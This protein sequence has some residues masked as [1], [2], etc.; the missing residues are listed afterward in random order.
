MLGAGVVRCKVLGQRKTGLRAAQ[1]ATIVLS[2][3]HVDGLQAGGACFSKRSPVRE[4]VGEPL[5]PSVSNREPMACNLVF[6][7]SD[8]SAPRAA[9]S[10]ST[11]SPCQMRACDSITRIAHNFS[12]A[13]P[14][15]TPRSTRAKV[16]Q[17]SDD[18]SNL[19]RLAREGKRDFL[20]SQSAIQ[21][22]GS[23]G[24]DLHQGEQLER[25]TRI[26]SESVSTTTMS[27]TRLP[28]RSAMAVAE[29]VGMI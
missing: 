26:E 2:D 15:F 28:S 5:Q 20:G 27:E 18:R 13:A 9:L 11:N 25:S 4:D 24:Q 3:G 16:S 7:T 29:A 6:S 17:T 12:P 8:D 23:P 1:K 19:R 22:R 21:T 10:V 14:R